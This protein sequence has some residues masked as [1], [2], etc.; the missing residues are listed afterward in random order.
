[1]K[2]YTLQSAFDIVVKHARQQQCQAM[3]SDRC[4]YRSSTGLKCF[5]GALIPDELYDPKMEGYT[6]AGILNHPITNIR[7]LFDANIDDA[8]LE[9][10]LTSLQ[11]IHDSNYV[12]H[13]EMWF[14]K[15]ALEFNLTKLPLRD[16]YET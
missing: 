4:L 7:Q 12:E 3:E 10:F 16:V 5:I 14:D 8:F 9:N 1:M 6:V 15:F 2:P 11:K 13:W